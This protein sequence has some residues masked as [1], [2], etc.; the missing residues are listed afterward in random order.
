MREH[1]SKASYQRAQ[2]S[3]ARHR[4]HRLGHL[5]DCRSRVVVA[6]QGNGT[7]MLQLRSRAELQPKRSGAQQARHS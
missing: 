5:V 3:M 2:Q 7:P 6:A 1:D 4:C